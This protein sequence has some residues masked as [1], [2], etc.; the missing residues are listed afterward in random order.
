M[1][2]F[3]HLQPPHEPI[4]RLGRGPGANLLVRGQFHPSAGT[5]LCI[6]RGLSD[7]GG[8]DNL[9]LGRPSVLVEQEPE[10]DLLSHAGGPLAAVE[11]GLQFL[12]SS[13]HIARVSTGE[14]TNC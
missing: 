11:C 10:H 8:R 7:R 6:C 4:L 12:Q 5:V 3:P 13:G 9:L 1:S 2:P 14:R